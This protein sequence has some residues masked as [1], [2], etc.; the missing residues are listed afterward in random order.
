MKKA[1]LAIQKFCRLE[2][3]CLIF[4][5]AAVVYD[6]YYIDIQNPLTTSL[7]DMG[8]YNHGLFIVWGALS[9]IA[10][11]LNMNM[12]YR[13]VGVKTKI[14]YV[15]LGI[16][17]TLLTITC[18][19]MR[20]ESEQDPIFLLHFYSSIL[21]AVFAFFALMRGL[22]P[23]WVKGRQYQVLTVILLAL[24]LADMICLGIFKQMGLFEFIPLMLAFVVFFF[25]NYTKTFD[26]PKKKEEIKE[27]YGKDVLEEMSEK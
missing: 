15:F 4:L 7:S 9:G 11:V 8:R 5:I 6:M 20:K 19:T 22:I 16:S 12:L 1:F 18:F 14:G 27:V 21:F 23:A 25:T 17:V 24:L 26:I 3:V 13:K 2:V 10:L